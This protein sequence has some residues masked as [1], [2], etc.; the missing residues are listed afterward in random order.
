M[1]FEG[2][3]RARKARRAEIRKAAG[4]H[5]VRG[6]AWKPLFVASELPKLADQRA[7]TQVLDKRCCGSRLIMCKRAS[8]K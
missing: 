7:D 8:F 4:E 6:S 3:H 2:G 1:L 5:W